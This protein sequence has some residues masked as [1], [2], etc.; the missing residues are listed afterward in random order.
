MIQLQ[1]QKVYVHQLQPGMYVSGLDRPW[2]GTPCYLQGFMIQ[3]SKQIQKLSFYCDYVYIYIKKSA[4]NL[5][6][7]VVHKVG[8]R[9]LPTGFPCGI[10]QGEVAVVINFRV[11]MGRK[12]ELT[13]ILD[14]NKKRLV[15]KKVLELSGKE[16]NIDIAKNLPQDAYDPDP[17]A[18][19]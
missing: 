2:L 15:R 19:F 6:I 13:V 14:A 10:N 12:P 8:H 17:E 3:S 16:G 18:L 4:S 5:N 9:A 7:A 11:G 1:P